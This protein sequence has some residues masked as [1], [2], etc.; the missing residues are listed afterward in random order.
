MLD[1]GQSAQDLREIGLAELGGSAGAGGKFGKAFDLFA[2]H[3]GTLR[4]SWDIASVMKR[5]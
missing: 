3:G 5:T 2:G 4:H 1:L